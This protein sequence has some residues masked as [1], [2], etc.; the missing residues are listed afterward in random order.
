MKCARE[1]KM[2]GDFHMYDFMLPH[3]LDVFIYVLAP[4]AFQ[5]SVIT[6]IIIRESATEKLF[7][8]FLLFP[9]EDFQ[10]EMYLVINLL[11][12]IQFQDDLM[13][14]KMLSFVTRFRCIMQCVIL[15]MR[16]TYTAEL[17]SRIFGLQAKVHIVRDSDTLLFLI[18]CMD[19]LRLCSCNS[20]G[21]A[22]RISIW[23]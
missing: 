1:R 8:P 20:I 7:S 12:V 13:Q 21:E 14:T 15:C 22:L 11:Q 2:N 16:S 9:S 4:P 17:F 10:T 3:Y 5:F 23:T 18:H 19:T 6:S